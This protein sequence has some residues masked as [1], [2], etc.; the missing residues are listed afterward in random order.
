M[1]KLAE[2]EQAKALM[3]EARNWS[4]VKWLK[5]KKRVRHAA[6]KANGALDQLEQQVKAAWSE[7]LRLAYERLTAKGSERRHR[8]APGAEPISPEIERLASQVKDAD[9]EA[10]RAHVEAEETF[11]KAERI[12]ST[13]MAREGC[14]KAID[15][16]DL[17]EQAIA[18]AEAGV[19]SSPSAV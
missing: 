13:R 5:E 19:R 4:V 16:W 10:Y 2:V 9:E 14:R 15:S 18:K 12:L 6:D 7:D 8:L 17:H 3:S 1:Q 11:D